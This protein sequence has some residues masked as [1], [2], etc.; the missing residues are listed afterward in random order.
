MTGRSDHLRGLAITT[1]GVLILTPDSLLVRLIQADTWTL[2]FW[3]GLLMFAA[4]MALAAVR[5]RGD[6]RRRF[7]A[8]GPTGA[9][10]AAAFAGSMVFF[11]TAIKATAVANVLVIVSAT[12]LFAALFSRLFLG[13][14][15]PARTWAA[16]A[17]GMVAIAAIVGDGLGAGA[18][19]GNGAALA[20]SACMAVALTLMRKTRSDNALPAM[21]LS[22][23]MVAV[24]ALVPSAPFSVRGEDLALLALLGLVVVPAAFVLTMVGPRYLPAAE[25]GLI[26]LLETVLGP[27]WVWLA[28][29]ERPPDM[30]F[31]GGAV[32]IATLVVHAWLGLRAG[33]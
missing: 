20:C 10:A 33:R 3:R 31:M 24:A 32:L 6:T 5:Y 21:A 7:R 18:M 25:V 30:A 23:L 13:E 28:I 16:I 11:V 29:G 26:F 19:A 27:F 17:V 8:L 2:L 22:G 1:A 14:P 12:P 4:L 9:W 15:V